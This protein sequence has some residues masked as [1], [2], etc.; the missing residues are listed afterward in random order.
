VPIE[1]IAISSIQPNPYNSRKEIDRVAVNLLADSMREEGF[2]GTPLRARVVN[3]HYELAWGHQRLEAL[4]ALGEKKITLDVVKLTDVQ[5]AEESLIANLPRQGLP[6]LDKAEAIARL[7]G[8]E[9]D[10]TVGRKK[11]G[12]V[13]KVATLLGYKNLGTIYD[14]VRMTE[15]SAPTKQVMREKNTGRTWTAVANRIGG[16]EMI[17]HAAKNEI[18]QNDLKA[19]EAAVGD[20]SKEQRANVVKKIVERKVT[21]PKDVTNLARREQEKQ[22]PKAKMPPDLMYWID[23]WT[24]D[25]KVWT[26]EIKAATKYKEYI[27]EYPEI[28][29]KFKDAAEEFIAALSDL[30]DL[31]GQTKKW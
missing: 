16:E 19:M 12:A 29:T 20:L 3:G 13:Q 15:M 23:K 21:E 18:S 30:L 14:Y 28:A 10:F 9:P 31:R 25:L 27:H 17:R 26:K 5:M 22:K 8:L 1:L 4:K 2:W 7:I 6:E 24:G 11:A